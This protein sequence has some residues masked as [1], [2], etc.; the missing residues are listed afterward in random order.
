MSASDYQSYDGAMKRKHEQGPTDEATARRP[1]GATTADD[2]TS[3][4]DAPS[5][6]EP[7]GGAADGP[8]AP[9]TDPRIDQIAARV[10]ELEDQLL[11]AKAEQQNIRKRAANELSEALRFA[12]ASVFK[13]LL[14]TID[15]FDRTLEQSNAADAK[16]LL[17]GVR[18]IYDNFMK[19][20]SDCRV[21]VIDARDQPF[22]PHQHEAVQQV[23]AAG[24]QRPG[25]V[26]AVLQKGFKLEDRVLRPAKVVIAGHDTEHGA[27]RTEPETDTGSKEI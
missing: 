16:T 7:A 19:A 2:R 13:S 6:R 26:V 11:R 23:P 25:T 15:D 1:A 8:R 18:L 24:N 12:N 5:P 14:G 22:D 4:G 3:G 21:E 17:D 20:L 27:P 10:A 9:E